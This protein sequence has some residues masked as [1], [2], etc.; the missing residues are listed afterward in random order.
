MMRNNWPVTQGELTVQV[1]GPV[2]LIGAHGQIVDLPSASQ[3]R[4]LGALAIH[5]SRPVRAEWL[6]GVLD[7]TA[8]ALRTSVSRLR[9]VV[10]DGPLQTTVGGYWLDAPVDAALACA[11]IQSASG[12]PVA[13]T[14]ALGRW[15]GHALEEFTDEPWAVGE[16]ARLA[17]I[18]ATAVE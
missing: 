12:D 7:V 18:R 2:R 9:R 13:L 5:A 10:G 14:R 4:L 17:A 11:E 15:V 8:G 3:R 6:C 1:L 16:V